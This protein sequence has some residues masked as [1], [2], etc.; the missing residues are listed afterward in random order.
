M[1]MDSEAQS[2]DAKAAEV[3]FRRDLCRYRVGGEPLFDDEFDGEAILTIFR[4]RIADVIADISA[5]PDVQLIDN[6]LEVGAEC[7]Q[8]AAALADYLKI[9]CWA[10]DISLESLRALDFYAP[11]LGLSPGPTRVCCDLARLP[12][13][14]N[15]FD[16]VVAYQTLHHFEHP[17]VIVAEI[18]RVNRR[19]FVVGDEPTRRLMRAFVGTQRHGIYSLA[20][21]SRGRLR[22]FFEDTFLRPRC[23]EVGYGVIE[24]EELTLAGW[25]RCIEPWYACE[26]YLGANVAG[27][28]PIDGTWNRSRLLAS[29]M[30][31][32]V[33]FVGRVRVEGSARS[34]AEPGFI[35]PDCLDREASEQ[36]LRSDANGLRCTQC[37][38]QFPVV[39]GIPILLPTALRRALYPAL[40]RSSVT[41]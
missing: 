36:T 40:D 35:C 11:R 14:A 8:R 20:Q 30:G 15:A 1:R 22:R 27:G 29:L 39:E 26:W 33:S 6:C 17:D 7:C 4:R 16:L 25:R 5:L 3:R 24:N 31:A 23:H 9:P 37:H 19:L 34:I 28:Q 2:L 38:T 12:F 18:R 21:R 13:R 10:A 41:C 32:S